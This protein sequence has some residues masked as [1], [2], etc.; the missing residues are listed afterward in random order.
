MTSNQ[1]FQ[2]LMSCF[3][4]QPS[5]ELVKALGGLESSQSKELCSFLDMHMDYLEMLSKHIDQAVGMLDDL[6]IRIIV[7][8]EQKT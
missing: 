6:K 1:N 5:D 8:S 3:M 4:T 2:G 7:A